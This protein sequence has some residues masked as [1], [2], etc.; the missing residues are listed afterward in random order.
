GNYINDQKLDLA[1]EIQVAH[2]TVISSGDRGIAV[3]GALLGPGFVRNNAV[4]GA[5][6][7][8]I[9]IGGDVPSFAD[10]G[11]HT[12]EDPAGLG[13]VDVAARDFHLTPGS[14]LR[15]AGVGVPELAVT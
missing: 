7:Q 3:F 10:E 12:A 5:P 11:N 9:G 8:L 14:P 15:D 1:A 2:N 13:F 4:A 6:T